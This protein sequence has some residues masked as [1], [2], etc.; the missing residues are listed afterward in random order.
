MMNSEISKVYGQILKE[1][2][3]EATGCTEPIALALAGAKVKAVLGDL[4]E[5]VEVYCS[6]NI[7]KNVKAVVVPNSGGIKGIDTAV[8][9]GMCAGDPDAGLQVISRVSDEEREK[10]KEH[11]K[12]IKLT[13]H[14]EKD[15]PTLYIRIEA[16]KGNEKALVEIR[17]TH[18]NFT[19]I[20]RNDE[21][22]LDRECC[23][24][25]DVGA[26]KSLLN[27]ADIL[28]YAETV[29]LDEVK[30]LIEL[31]IK[32]NTA[33]SERGLKDKWGEQVGQTM[34]S[35]RE[36]P[37]VRFRARAKAA[38]GSDARM[39]GCP[40]AVVINSGSGN[41]GMTVSLPVIE[42]AEELKVSHE[43][44]IRALVLANLIALHQK[45]Y[46]GYLSAYC[47]AVSAAA[48]AGCGICWLKGGG[49]EEICDVITNCIAVVGGMVCDGAKS[50][51]AGKISI[52]VETALMSVDMALNHN[53]FRNGEGMVKKDVERTIEAYGRM[54]AE[55]MKET[56]IEILNIMLED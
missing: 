23:S 13:C 7:I 3:Q 27:V 1:E 20:I 47:G 43:K 41:Q 46:I 17:Q 50:S 25:E 31:Q 37:D 11:L 54:A 28:E 48:G 26:D 35:C 16:F 56:D 21:V 55:G 9:L 42:Y 52:A 44:L 53:V 8:V 32:D 24:D 40:M 4:P 5:R 29:D 30:D 6:G 34:L 22:L 51:C 18:S 38:A 19:K 49:Y 10:L 45:R 36:C 33:I 2:L 12:Q 15:V 39:N 14:L